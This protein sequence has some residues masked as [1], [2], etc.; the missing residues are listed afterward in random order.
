MRP[1]T[2][3]IGYETRHFCVVHMYMYLEWFLWTFL[4]FL[5]LVHHVVCGLPRSGGRC[6]NQY[7]NTVQIET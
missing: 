1:G 2:R 7:I 4:G 5:D 6:V 3:W